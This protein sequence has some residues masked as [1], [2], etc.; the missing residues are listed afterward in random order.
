MDATASAIALSAGLRRR[1]ISAE[2]LIESV[3]E[4][5]EQVADALNPIAVKLYDRARRRARHADKALSNGT[6]GPLCGVPVTIKDSQWLAGVPCANGSRSLQDFIPDRTS[7]AIEKLEHAGAVIFARTTAPEFSLSGITDSELYGRTSNPWDPNRT[8]GGSSGG[9]AVAVATSLGPLSLGGDGGGSIRI[10]AAFCG[11]VGFKPSFGLV[12]REPCFRSWKSLVCY[13]PLARTVADARL[14]LSV[15]APK[16]PVPPISAGQNLRGRRIVVSEDLGF[17]PLDPHVR[18]CFRNLVDELADAGA[19]LIF[20]NPG[21]PSSVKVWGITATHDA[22]KH[23]QLDPGSVDRVSEATRL[24]LEFGAQFTSADFQSAQEQRKLIADAYTR[25]F[26]RTGAC[27]L[28]TPTLGCEAFHHGSVF[29]ERIGNTPIEWPWIDWAGFLYDANLTGMPACAL[30][31]G[32]GG[33]GLPLSVQVLG[34]MGSDFEILDVA[35]E[36]E[37]LVQWNHRYANGTEYPVVQ[38]I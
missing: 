9:A 32:L 24:F 26:E 36:I 12:D 19:E 35:E 7:A 2:E 4:R 5:T 37:S 1:Q 27:A 22:W 20:D 17:A 16:A 30:P 13:G 14:M 28:L 31:T 15:L 34:P 6:A 33:G 25:L 38:G 10:P 11:V 29:P 8:P 23:R 18:Y 3:I 21:L